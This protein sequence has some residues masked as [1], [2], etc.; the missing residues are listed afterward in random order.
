MYSFSGANNSTNDL[1][2]TNCSFVEL[3]SINRSRT[4]S[5]YLY[6]N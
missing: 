2:T 1:A 6:S 3:Q 5:L 4:G